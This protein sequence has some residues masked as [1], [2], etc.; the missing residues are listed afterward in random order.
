VRRRQFGLPAASADIAII[1]DRVMSSAAGRSGNN[2]G[3]HRADDTRA[4]PCMGLI[5]IAAAGMSFI[6]WNAIV[7]PCF[8]TAS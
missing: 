6:I 8:P 4:E 1:A 2:G 7:S 3:H 5:L